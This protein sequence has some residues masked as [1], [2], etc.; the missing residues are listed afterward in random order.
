MPEAILVDRFD[1]LEAH[2]VDGERWTA[3]GLRIQTLAVTDRVQLDELAP[4]G[5]PRCATSRAQRVN[6]QL[7]SGA[8]FT[9]ARR[10][11]R[12]IKTGP[13]HHGAR[14]TFRGDLI[15]GDDW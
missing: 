11:G 10:P 14:S 15:Q 7:S 4:R 1:T 12:L 9:S 3:C 8:A 5:C 2:W 6:V 13:L